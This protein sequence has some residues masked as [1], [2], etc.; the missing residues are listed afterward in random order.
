MEKKV[1]SKCKE[2]K[3][4][5]EFGKDRTKKSG[6]KSQCK[7]CVNITSKKYKLLNPD[8][9]KLSRKKTYEKHFDIISIKK[10]EYERKNKIKDNLRRKNK[11]HSDPLYKLKVN[12][13]RRILT[14]LN[15]KNIIKSNTTFN[16]I[17]CSPEFLKQ[18]IEELFSNEMSWEN[19]GLFGWHIDHIIPLSSAKNES[20]FYNLC[21]YT[22]LQP[23]W[24]EDNLKKSNK[25]L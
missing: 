14:Y 5:C 16:I 15:S 17:G 7:E 22:N 11:Y 6:Y 25:L 8:K 23:L 2:E 12:L 21:H 20:E 19:Y 9:I 10:K 1:C 18:H 3:E 13:R 4:V 24:A